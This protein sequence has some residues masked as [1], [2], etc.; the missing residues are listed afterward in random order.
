MYSLCSYL[1]TTSNLTWPDC[2]NKTLKKQKFA[3]VHYCK[4]ATEGLHNIRWLHLPYVLCL[5]LVSKKV[6]RPRDSTE[7]CTPAEALPQTSRPLVTPPPHYFLLCSLEHWISSAYSNYVPLL[8]PATISFH[9]VMLPLAFVLI[10]V[11]LLWW[12]HLSVIIS[13]IL[14]CSAIL[15]HSP[16]PL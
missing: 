14:F 3:Q 13:L 15:C 2:I 9:P 6:S 5:Q 4:V 16:C 11:S 7:S 8:S 12:H 1:I 10:I